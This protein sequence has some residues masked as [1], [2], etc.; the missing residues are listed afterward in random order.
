MTKNLFS[1]LILTI[2]LSM[3]LSSQ[4]KIDGVLDEADWKNAHLIEDLYEVYPY[5]LKEVEDYKTQI[6]ILE[7]KEGLYFGFK[8]F[9]SNESMR[10]MNHLRDQERSLSDKNGFSI[11]FDGD[12]VEGYNFFISSSG[13]IGDATIRDEKERNWDWDADWQSAATVEEGVWYSESFIPWTVVSMKPQEGDLRKIRIAFYRMLMGVGRGFSTIKGSP[14]EN[15]YLS[16]FNDYKVK[17]YSGSKLDFFPYATLTEDIANSDLI[18]KSGAEIFWK[19]DSSKQVNMTL[20]PDFGQVESDEVV[21][22]FS[23]FETFYSDKRPFF[24]E[25]NNLFDVRSM[26][27]RVINTRRIGGKPDYNC[28]LFGEDEEYCQNNQADSSEIDFAL[29]YTQKGEVDFGLLTASERDQKFSKGRDYYALRLNTKKDSLRYGYLGTY[30]NKPVFDSNAL[31]NSFDFEYLPSKAHRFTSNLL[32]S[33]VEE[34]D[35]FGL[36]FGYRYDLNK[37]F[38]SGIGIN[39]YDENLDLNDMGYLILN[40]RMMFNGRTQFKKTSF[41]KD[42]IFRFRLY[43]IGYGSKFNADSSRE[44]SNFALKLEANFIDLSELK[45][46]IFYRSTGKNTRITRGSQL[47]PYIKMPK[48]TGGYIEFTGPRKPLYIYSLR[49]ERG[50][51]SEHS[52][53]I[54]WKNS[55]RGFIKFMPLDNL[56]FSMMY[57]HDD[58]KDWLN[59]LDDNLLA[60]YERKQ[61]TS[62]LELEWFHKNKHELRVKAQMVAFTGRDP[63]PYLGDQAGK[64]NPVNINLSPITISELAFQVRYRYELMPL[65]YLY[66]VYSKGGRVSLQDDEEDLFNLYRRP[67]NS[68]EKENFTVKLRYRF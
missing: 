13:S 11:D 6:L 21:V 20:N 17:N 45:T 43:E 67:W 52:P 54:G 66:V 53:E 55:S 2:F 44:S 49:L 64:L 10:I 36:A 63:V 51:G 8:N 32:H 22:N 24:S 57:Q 5:S 9:Q 27:H 48:G 14:F 56:S 16:V 12:G 15:V 60:A 62:I 42:S 37:D 25:N 3:N 61:R 30:V 29:K 58:E 35:G 47:S 18:A 46:E 28:S 38:S 1:G 31:V 33:N 19:I 39:Y 34:T 26:M 7:T 68:P 50:R 23:A 40:D 41:S 59:W 65:S 4:I